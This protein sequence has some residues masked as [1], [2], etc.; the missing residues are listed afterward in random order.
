M[1][2]VPR[3]GRSSSRLTS[4]KHSG[5]PEEAR[6]ATPARVTHPADR[7]S[8]PMGPR[9]AGPNGVLAVEEARVTD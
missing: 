2:E 6:V 7:G 3:S 9:A 4:K 8:E 1:D 5:I